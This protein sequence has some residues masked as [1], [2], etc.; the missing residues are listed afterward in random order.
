M[1]KKLELLKQVK[2]NPLLFQLFKSTPFIGLFDNLNID[3]FDII[4]EETLKFINKLNNIFLQ[5][6]EINSKY[7]DNLKKF[8]KFFKRNV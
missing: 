6:D 3:D 2:D 7:S 1:R 4:L 5:T 8:I